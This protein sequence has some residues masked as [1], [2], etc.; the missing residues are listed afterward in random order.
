[1]RVVFYTSAISGAGRLVTGMSIGNA[2]TRKGVSCTY[3][4]AHSSPLGHLAEDFNTVWV[5]VETE[6]DLAP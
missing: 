6:E 3:T 5:P 4:I 2:L 1:V